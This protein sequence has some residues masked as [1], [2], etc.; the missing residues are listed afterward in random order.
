MMPTSVAAFAYIFVPSEQAADKLQCTS[1]LSP[2]LHLIVFDL[3]ISGLS[4][5]CVVYVILTN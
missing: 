1:H 2:S 3:Q 5:L 4:H